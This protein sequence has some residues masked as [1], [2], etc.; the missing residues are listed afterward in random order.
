VR[1]G[2]NVPT[3]LSNV[4]FLTPEGKT[5]LIVLNEDKNEKDFTIKTGQK[6]ANISLAAGAVGTFILN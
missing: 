6:T 5:V 3:G 4:A 1:I 2:S